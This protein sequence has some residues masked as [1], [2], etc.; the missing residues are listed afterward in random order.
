MTPARRASRTRDTRE[1]GPP[2]PRTRD[3]P[4]T[5]ARGPPGGIRHGAPRHR[6][7]PS[8]RPCPYRRPSPALPRRR[9]AP[10][11]APGAPGS[12]RPPRTARGGSGTLHR[13]AP[14][15]PTDRRAPGR[16]AHEPGPPRNPRRGARKEAPQSSPARARE[17][18]VGG[19]IGP[20]CR[21]PPRGA[22][23]GRG[24]GPPPPI[25]LRPP[26]PRARRSDRRTPGP[27]GSSSAGS[28]LLQGPPEVLQ[29]VVRVLDPHRDPDEPVADA[30]SPG[31]LGRELGLG[32]ARS[33]NSQGV[34]P[35]Q[36]GP[37]Q[38][39]LE[40]LLEPRPGLVA[41]GKLE[42]DH[43]AAGP[44]GPRRDL[45][46]G[47]GGQTRVPHPR[48]LR[49]LLEH[50]GQGRG[51]VAVAL[52]AKG[53]GLRATDR[54][55]GIERARYPAQIDRPVPDLADEVAGS[56]R[57]PAGEV[58][59][60]AYEL[61]GG[62][63]HQV[64]T[65]RERV[66]QVRAGERV[67]DD[68]T[69]A[70]GAAR[71]GQDLQVG[72][73][74]RGV[75]YGLRVARH[76]ARTECGGQLL[77]S[78]RVG[79]RDVDAPPRED[80]RHH[81]VAPSVQGRT[82]HD[83]IAAAGQRGQHRGDRGHPGGEGD[84]PLA[85]LQVGQ[86]LLEGRPGRVV[87]PRVNEPGGLAPAD[88]LGQ[89]LGVVERVRGGL[90]DRGRDRT[91]LAQIDPLTKGPR[92]EPSLGHGPKGTVAPV[93]ERHAAVREERKVVTAL[94]A[95]LVG[96]TTLAERLEAEEVKVVLGEAIA[97]IVRAVEDFGG[98]I[99]DLAG[100]GVLA[101]FGA[102]TAHE[103]DPERAVRAGLRTVEEIRAY[104]DEVARGWGIEGFDV[105]VGITTGPVVVG[106][107][108]G[109]SRVEYSAVGDTVNTAP[110]LQG[111]AR[112][113]WG[114]V[115]QDTYRQVEG[116]FEWDRPL[117]LELKG[118]TEHVTAH[119]LIGVATTAVRT[120]GPERLKASLVGRDT[121][122]AVAREALREV[123]AGAGGILLV[124]GEAGIGKTR[125]IAELESS[126]RDDGGGP[127]ATWLEGRCVSYGEAM[128]YLPFRDLLREWLG[129]GAHDPEVRIRVALRR[130][131]GRLFGDRAPEIYPY[132]GA[133]LGL[134]LEPEA[135]AR[136]EELSPEA[137]QYRTFEVV[138]HLLERLARDGPV[139]A[140]L[141][142]LHW[143][144]PT[145]LQLIDDLLGATEGSA[146]LLVLSARP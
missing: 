18:P 140:A 91:G 35:S 116:L 66:A 5:P 9:T 22:R 127:A 119:P 19:A 55:P 130:S 63:H 120:R 95:D 11:R 30:G 87:P 94:F 38:R 125:L 31:L 75:A 60:A 90:V 17:G 113:G 34:D 32:H 62:M 123:R 57:H 58:G 13:S 81:G 115:G 98:T 10:P 70:V 99:K 8:A 101:L 76:G 121:E 50:P 37:D 78:V 109:G 141:E 41:A 77:R 105:R 71:P 96:S 24:P 29:D 84:R 51:V 103:D 15:P 42:R 65:E 23:S 85:S 110:R 43:A 133:M 2:P 102:P 117:E 28:R 36:A 69:G 27:P 128:P 143:A 138:R 74:Q 1:T 131:V 80:L 86:D 118:K 107:I 135:S 104:A 20:P 16:P 93:A 26:R 54:Q 45:V 111:E 106:L 139:V 144:D 114:L 7:A 46:V 33:V 47:V 53:Q 44:K 25:S 132:L 124:L 122:L 39:Y 14:A 82:R 100:D 3:P 59:V 145:S 89:D 49:M 40:G 137:L 79:H 88:R 67:V 72:N 92:R 142:D 68:Q 97:R 48:D 126:L 12:C 73:G 136:L 112:P 6:T 52:H 61:R 83:V 4:A 56:H 64:R 129:V 146:L 21:S 134:A 108:G